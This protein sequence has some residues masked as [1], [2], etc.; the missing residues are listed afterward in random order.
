MNIINIVLVVLLILDLIIGGI[1]LSKMKEED[2]TICVFTSMIPAINKDLEA[3]LN[4]NK[5]HQTEDQVIALTSNFLVGL[6]K[7]D[8]DLL[9][10]Y[11]FLLKRNN[12]EKHLVPL[13]RKIYITSISK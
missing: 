1:R 12:I 13:F 8:I 3:F 9:R 4:T 7:K 6:L 10:E 11:P 5:P 2:K